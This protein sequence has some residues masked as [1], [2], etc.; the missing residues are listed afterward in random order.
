MSNNVGTAVIK[1]VALASGAVLGTLIARWCDE[2]LTQRAQTQFDYDKT[3]YEQGLT[4]IT[5][6]PQQQPPVLEEQE[7]EQY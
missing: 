7:Q 2:L 6:P 5:L 1:V 3:R 4:P